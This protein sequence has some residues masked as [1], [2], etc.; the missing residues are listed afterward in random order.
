M[1]TLAINRKLFTVDE[2]H[3]MADAGILPADRRFELVRGEIIEMTIPKSPHSS[4]VNRLTYLFVTRF[5]SAAVV[6]PQ[7]PLPIDLHS[8]PV[9][10]LVLL[11]PKADFYRASHPTPA[12][13]LLVIEV[14]DTTLTYDTRVKASMYAEAGV[15]EYWILDVNRERLVVHADPVGREYRSRRLLGRDDSVQLVKVPAAEFSVTDI[16]GP[17]FT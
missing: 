6:S 15:P 14:S 5:G 2:Y 4:S 3:R 13:V 17:K 1:A 8:E 11:E 12:D 9:P 16:L 7:N 10:D